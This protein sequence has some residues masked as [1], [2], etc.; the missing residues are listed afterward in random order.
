[1]DS[2]L[3]STTL[4]L[5]LVLVLSAIS[6]GLLAFLVRGPVERIIGRFVDGRPSGESTGRLTRTFSFTFGSPPDEEMLAGARDLSAP[7]A[8]AASLDPSSQRHYR[9]RWR[10]AQAL[11]PSAPDAAVRE[12]HR[13]VADLM[14]E[15]G[16]PAAQL[17]HVAT[18]DIGEGEA[19][20][21]IGTVVGSLQAARSAA[22]G[23]N[24]ANAYREADP[25]DLGSAMDL[26]ARV[27]ANLLPEEPA[28]PST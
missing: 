17:G 2:E 14:R 21:A 28:P 24:Q 9:E 15:L 23:I 26:Y 22:R 1:M 4:G 7:T 12:A 19:I 8:A 20:D 18:I 27:V 13:L 25:E 3:G 6:L 10:R 16:I 11:F 5:V